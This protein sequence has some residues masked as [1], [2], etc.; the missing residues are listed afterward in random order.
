MDTSISP[1]SKAGWLGGWAAVLPD[2]NRTVIGRRSWRRALIVS[3]FALALGATGCG[4]SSGSGSKSTTSST[5]SSTSGSGVPKV[6]RAADGTF[7]AQV[8]NASAAITACTT[9]QSELGQQLKK[10]GASAGVA[11]VSFDY[12]QD[13]SSVTVP[14]P[15]NASFALAAGDHVAFSDTATVCGVAVP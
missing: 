3:V 4:G 12:P 8:K 5:S 15:G 10:L 13:P 7:S 11:T 9:Q 14:N 2:Q 6:Q 1:D